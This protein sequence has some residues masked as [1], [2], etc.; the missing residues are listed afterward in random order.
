M[1]MIRSMIWQD[2]SLFV[3][4]LVL[5]AKVLV[6]GILG[7]VC[8][9][10]VCNLLL[11]ASQEWFYRPQC[12]QLAVIVRFS[13]VHLFPSWLVLSRNQ[14]YCSCCSAQMAHKLF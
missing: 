12:T 6:V 9:F 5:I 8:I 14:V 2:L 11:H 13:Y 7:F 10:G 4:Y 1:K 3:Y